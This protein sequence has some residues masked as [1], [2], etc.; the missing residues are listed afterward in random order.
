MTGS[1]EMSDLVL[2]DTTT[3]ERW[4]LIPSEYTGDMAYL[5]MGEKAIEPLHDS[6]PA[7]EM[8]REIA[9]RFGIEQEFSEGRDMEAWVRW[10][11]AENQ[12]EY[13]HFPSFDELK[14]MGVYRYY[15]PD[16]LAVP[17]KDFR[18]DPEA[19]KL[20]TPS[21]KVEIFSSELWEMAKTWT[22]NDPLPGDEITPLPE[23]TATWEGAEEARENDQ[24][25]LQ[26][27]SHHFKGRVHSSYGNIPWLH[28]AHPQKAWI[29]P[30]DAAERGVENEEL[31]EVFNDR[32]RI[33]VRAFVTPR[34]MPGVISVPQGAW[35]R[36]ENGV[37]VGGAANTLTSL[38]PT[39]YAKGNGQHTALVQVEKAKG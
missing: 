14:E 20:E 1:A 16:G 29:N 25:P 18:A 10:M 8:C 15:D 27:I 22:F 35:Y 24:Y 36:N 30:L 32:G 3:A 34:I 7:Y 5:I 4:D 11:Q 17:L 12:K 31:M 37:D 9:K 39:P 33:R 6:K 19:N 13:P 26:M 21:G 28:E 2:P 38:H 23:Y